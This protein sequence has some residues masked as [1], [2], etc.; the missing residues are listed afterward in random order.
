MAVGKAAIE[1]LQVQVSAWAAKG[2][3]DAKLVDWQ[4]VTDDARI[5]LKWLYPK[6]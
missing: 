6:I 5:K 3:A 4:F 1:G 2:N